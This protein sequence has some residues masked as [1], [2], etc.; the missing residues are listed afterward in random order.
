MAYSPEVYTT[1]SVMV[2]EG[3]ISAKKNVGIRAVNDLMWYILKPDLGVSFSLFSRD[4]PPW[5][6]E[7][8][9]PLGRLAKQVYWVRDLMTAMFLILKILAKSSNVCTDALSSGTL[10]MTCR[11]ICARSV[12]SILMHPDHVYKERE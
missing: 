1:W 5:V 6:N 2:S 12:V 4:R 9:L 7:N 10:N 11:E 8:R 3:V